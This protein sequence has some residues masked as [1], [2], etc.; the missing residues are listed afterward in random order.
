MCEPE[1][2]F[3]ALFA[4]L[5]LPLAIIIGP[6]MQVPKMVSYVALSS[7]PFS[8]PFYFSRKLPSLF[9]GF[10]PHKIRPPLAWAS[11][12]VAPI[13]RIF[14]G[15]KQWMERLSSFSVSSM[16]AILHSLHLPSPASYG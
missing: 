12:L 9:L 15:V 8:T 7:Y 16:W 3:L 5:F 1:I 2:D 13:L 14:V 4:L 6:F 11:E 10:P